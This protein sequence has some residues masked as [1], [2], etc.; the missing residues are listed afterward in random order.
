MFESVR[1]IIISN[2]GILSTKT[3]VKN[4]QYLQK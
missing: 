1:K 3:T 2:S 4:V